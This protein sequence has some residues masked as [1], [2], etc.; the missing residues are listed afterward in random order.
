MKVIF[1]AKSTLHLVF[2]SYIKFC[3]TVFYSRLYYIEI[4]SN[5]YKICY[6][7][8]WIELPNHKIYKENFSNLSIRL[9]VLIHNYLF[10][11]E[12]FDEAQMIVFLIMAN[13]CLPRF[14]SSLLYKK[15]RGH[16]L[17]KVKRHLHL[18]HSKTRP[19]QIKKTQQNSSAENGATFTNFIIPS[20]LTQDKKT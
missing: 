1:C 10:Y 9:R 8:N 2:K 12:L 14:Q 4:P 15:H 3:F 17:Q 7:V 13:D 5:D 16:D 6:W 11:R 18:Q 19:L 20:S